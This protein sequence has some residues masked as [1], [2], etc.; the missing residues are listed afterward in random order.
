MTG[1]LDL[2]DNGDGEVALI[3]ENGEWSV[4]LRT[5]IEEKSDGSWGSKGGATPSGTLNMGTS[6]VGELSVID[7]DVGGSG[8]RDEIS[9]F[10]DA[11]RVGWYS[12]IHYNDIGKKSWDTGD[13]QSTLDAFV[14]RMNNEYH[15]HFV[16]CGGDN[17]HG[18]D[19]A[20]SDNTPSESQMVNWIGAI[21]DKLETTGG[22]DNSG[23]D[24]PVFY[25]Y[26]DHEYADAG[27]WNMSN[28][29]AAYGHD[30][31]ADTF[32]S[33]DVGGWHFVILNNSYST[34][35][36]F[37]DGTSHRSETW[38][39]DGNDPF[40][41]VEWLRKDLRTTDKPVAVFTHHNLNHGSGNSPKE[42]TGNQYEVSELLSR[43]SNAVVIH[44]HTHHSWINTRRHAS[45]PWGVPNVFINEPEDN[46]W[47]ELAFHGTTWMVNRVAGGGTR[48]TIS[49]GLSQKY[50][51]QQQLDAHHRDLRQ[52]AVERRIFH[53][54]NI[55]A[56][57]FGGGTTGF[58]KNGYRM[59]TG[60]TS[61]T[62]AGY[63]SKELGV[64]GG[65]SDG[66]PWRG[67]RAYWDVDFRQN[68]SGMDAEVLSGDVSGSYSAQHI[69][70][71]MRGGDIKGSVGDGT[72]YNRTPTIISLSS[73]NQL[74]GRLGVWYESHGPFG[75]QV[76]FYLNGEEHEVLESD[77]PTG[78]GNG[79]YPYYYAVRNTDSTNYVLG[80]SGCWL[81]Q[82]EVNEPYGY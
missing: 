31:L 2:D 11:L 41:A 26:G 45:G 50:G 66:L 19:G 17:A 13:Q 20:K 35:S 76:R 54:S 1:T 47:G 34:Y 21:R 64:L 7:A 37:D 27:E 40:D 38:I 53:D 14:D 44:G 43:K 82:P 9:A 72:N 57:N 32:N 48:F 78:M 8:S 29:Y 23:L 49:R 25:T 52:G 75:D 22:S 69:G 73:N 70:F 55:R 39:P 42:F 58:G 59:A 81:Y 80:A 3:E 24:C 65:T 63:L 4:Y 62:E 30:S 60:T 71:V 15:P 77:L 56:Q 61:G 67:R 36:I 46:E 74:T 33:F 18:L 5:D 12:D 28:L 10:G 79:E 68:G 51:L 16:V 6:N